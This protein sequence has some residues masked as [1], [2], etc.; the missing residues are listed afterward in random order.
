MELIRR[1]HHELLCILLRR[2]SIPETQKLHGPRE[3]GVCMC[4]SRQ[5]SHRAR[6]RGDVD[7][8]P[9]HKCVKCRGRLITIIFAIIVG[10]TIVSTHL[11][12]REFDAKPARPRP[13]VRCV[14]LSATHKGSVGQGDAVGDSS[15]ARM[16]HVE[17][18]EVLVKGQNAPAL[19]V[20][21]RQQAHVFA[22]LAVLK[23]PEEWRCRQQRAL[24]WSRHT[25]AERHSRSFRQG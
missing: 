22:H 3:C 10:I 12:E 20:Q 25:E 23:Q 11:Q 5:S 2:L 14:H 13:V 9:S 8:G 17:D 4:Y 15:A 1:T 7:S 16:T 24:R 21:L 18:S 19:L 6:M